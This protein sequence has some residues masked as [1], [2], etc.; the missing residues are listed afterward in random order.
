[1]PPR[2]KFLASPIECFP[3]RPGLQQWHIKMY[4][5]DHEKYVNRGKM[6]IKVL[7]KY[8]E[9]SPEMK[10]LYVTLDKH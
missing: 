5:D 10:L 8:A 4:A 9:S 1:M 2:L 6:S 7:N 3:K